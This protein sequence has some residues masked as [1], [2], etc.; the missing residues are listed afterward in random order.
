MGSRDGDVEVGSAAGKEPNVIAME[1]LGEGGKGKGSVKGRKERPVDGPKGGGTFLEE[2][3]KAKLQE[4]RVASTWEIRVESD[5]E[6][7]N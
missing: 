4:I 5:D 6:H 7:K 1:V 2:P 3:P